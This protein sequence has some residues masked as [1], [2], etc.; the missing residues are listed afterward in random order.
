MIRPAVLE[1]FSVPLQRHYDSIFGPGFRERAS[2]LPQVASGGRLML[3]RPG[4]H[5]NPHRDP[6]HSMLTCLLYLAHPGDSE[7]FGT[8]IF[9][10]TDDSDANYKQTYYPEQNG[11]TCELAKVVPF[12]ANTM[13]VFLN[14][15]GA[16]GATIPPDAAATTLRYTYQFYVAPEK[17]QLA[18]LIRDLP[19]DRRRMWQ[20]KA[21]ITSARES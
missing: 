12:K 15:R 2:S 8:Q 10:V 13:L 18:A 5:L 7:T 17:D 9:A 1:R 19:T 11:R 14:S 16:H 6:K 21:S 3:R 20:N 4:Y